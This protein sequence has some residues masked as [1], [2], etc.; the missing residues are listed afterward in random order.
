MERERVVGNGCCQIHGGGREGA[1][2][3]GAKG[4]REGLDRGCKCSA[5]DTEGE[6]KAVR[7]LWEDV[8]GAREVQW[9]RRKAMESV[10]VDGIA[11]GARKGEEGDEDDHAVYGGNRCE[12]VAKKVSIERFSMIGEWWFVG[13]GGE[14][15]FVW[16]LLDKVLD[17]SVEVF[18]GS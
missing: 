16:Q 17:D 12:V 18:D 2:V 7:D 9:V 11:L 8:E 15:E 10:D 1:S 13:E 6:F 14:V 3:R 4:S 5:E